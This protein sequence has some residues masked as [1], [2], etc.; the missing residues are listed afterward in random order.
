MAIV[1]SK[2]VPGRNLASAK[3]RRRKKSANRLSSAASPNSTGQGQVGIRRAVGIGAPL[4]AFLGSERDAI[5]QVQSLLV[6][7]TT[8]MEIEH[9]ATG[10]YYPDV[11]GLGADILRRRVVNLDE[12]LLDGVVPED[13]TSIPGAI[14]E[15]APHLR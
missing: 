13:T 4:R 7:V 9:S 11:L 10:P 8:A 1:H 5:I 3:V 12:L 6:C 15:G 2:A 14:L